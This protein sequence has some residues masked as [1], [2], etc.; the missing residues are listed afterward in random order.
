MT[1]ESSG[2]DSVRFGHK[3]T[4]WTLKGR[5][6]LGW[7]KHFL[8]RLRDDGGFKNTVFAHSWKHKQRSVDP[9]TTQ[10]PRSRRLSHYRMTFP[11][12]P[13]V[14]CYI[15]LPHGIWYLKLSVGCFLHFCIS[16][17]FGPFFFFFFFN[18]SNWLP[19]AGLF[20]C[21]QSCISFLFTENK[22]YL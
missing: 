21:M 22:C 11:R 12:L 17:L 20:N 10:L 8:L 19:T 18:T 13:T 2:R 1:C 4:R 15:Y 6:G 3:N 7:S 16:D 9:S 5:L 14:L